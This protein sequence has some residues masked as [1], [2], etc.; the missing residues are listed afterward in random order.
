MNQNSDANFNAKHTA[1]PASP[2]FAV[3]KPLYSQVRDLIADQIS[4]G[5]WGPGAA[6]PN[7]NN[8]AQRFGVSIGTI[9]RAVEGLEEM[10]IVMR[11]QGRGTFVAGSGVPTLPERVRNIK[12]ER[13]EIKRKLIVAKRRAADQIEAM[14]LMLDGT[15]EVLEIVTNALA[16]DVVIGV[17]RSVLPGEIAQN[18]EASIERGRDL[19]ASLA[20]EGT[21]VVRA[22]DIVS[23]AT[24]QRDDE[25]ELGISRSQALLKVTRRAFAMTDRPVELRNARY[26]ATAVTYIRTA[27]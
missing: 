7:E 9:R 21:F 8:L 23:A 12:G 13:L 1:S 26:L 4:T 27:A 20:E 2:Q 14:R 3:P 16:S 22:D 11:R 18:I 17:E 19:Y 25:A 15:R 6:L 10:G 24:A 5:Q